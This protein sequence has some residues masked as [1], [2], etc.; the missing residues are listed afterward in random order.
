MVIVQILKI[1]LN[2]YQQL[3]AFEEKFHLPSHL[4]NSIV[5]SDAVST[6]R[7]YGTLVKFPMNEASLLK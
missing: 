6:A 3:S 7:V 5:D 4:T 1:M 2:N